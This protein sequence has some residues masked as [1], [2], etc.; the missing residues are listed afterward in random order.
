MASLQKIKEN[1]RKQIRIEIFDQ[2]IN[3]TV[4][5]E[6]WTIEREHEV[7][8]DGI[9]KIAQNVAL[10]LST[11]ILE[12]DLTLEEDGE[13]LEPTYENIL[14]HIP[15]DVAYFLFRKVKEAVSF[16]PK[17]FEIMSNT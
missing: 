5:C 7:S 16:D 11:I 9:E 15:S 12:W 6:N 1:T 3:A 2:V 10:Q 17:K 14:T 8:N 4:S 13:V